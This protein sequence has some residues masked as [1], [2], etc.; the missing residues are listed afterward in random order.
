MCV[1]SLGDLLQVVLVAARVLSILDLFLPS[2]QNCSVGLGVGRVRQ[3]G[4]A[5]T[6]LVPAGTKHPGCE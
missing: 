3:A 4:V 1:S 2:F 6:D 5:A